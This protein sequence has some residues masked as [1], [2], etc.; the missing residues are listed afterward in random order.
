[1]SKIKIWFIQKIKDVMNKRNGTS[2]LSRVRILTA[3]I[4][5]EINE[6][7]HLF[8][9]GSTSAG[10]GLPPDTSNGRNMVD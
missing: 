7:P 3:Q 2:K 1:M 4:C 8:Y 6:E 9:M 5:K 10:L